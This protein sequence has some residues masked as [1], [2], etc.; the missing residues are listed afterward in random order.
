MVSEIMCMITGFQRASAY[1]KQCHSSVKEE[2]HPN[3]AN[4]VAISTSLGSPCALFS[5]DNS[6]P[7]YQL[8]I[9]SPSPHVLNP[10]QVRSI[11]R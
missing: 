6:V 8:Y 4:N 2:L 9:L 5:Q 3:E 11:E 10:V 1:R 7:L